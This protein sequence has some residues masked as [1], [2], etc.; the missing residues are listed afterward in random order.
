MAAGERGGHF[1]LGFAVEHALDVVVDRVHVLGVV[2][3]V[4][5]EGAAAEL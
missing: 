3:G 2:D 1:K 5:P 4:K